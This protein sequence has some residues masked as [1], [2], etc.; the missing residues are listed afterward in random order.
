[1]KKRLVCK[2]TKRCSGFNDQN[3][4]CYHWG[5]HNQTVSCG[6]HCAK[7]FKIEKKF[8]S[9]CVSAEPLDRALGI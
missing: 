1:M 5:E 4:Q 9:V 2:Y 7:M 8:E 3:A 6:G